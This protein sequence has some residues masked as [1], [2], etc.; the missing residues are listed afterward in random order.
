MRGGAF[1][2][3]KEGRVG[4]RPLLLRYV[5]KEQGITD[6][7]SSPHTLWLLHQSI[8][9]FQTVFLPPDRG[10]LHGT[11]EEVED[12]TDGTYVTMDVQLIPMRVRPLL[13]LWRRHT[14]PE[15]IRVG[16][17]D[18]INDSLVVLIAILISHNQGP[19]AAQVHPA[20]LN[21]HLPQAVPARINLAQGFDAPPTL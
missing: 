16:S 11:G 15:Q 13:L 6:D 18:G 20:F 12:S 5:P 1:L 7:I 4:F 3:G 9:P 17:I 14:N 10:T 2:N 19:K 8:E 21:P